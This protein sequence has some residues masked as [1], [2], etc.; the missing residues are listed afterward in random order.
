MYSDVE[1]CYEYMLLYTDE[2]LS[3]LDSTKEVLLDI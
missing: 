1:E 3:I 2:Y